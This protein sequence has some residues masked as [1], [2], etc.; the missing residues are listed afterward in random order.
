MVGFVYL[1]VSD[2]S[3][4]LPERWIFD[5][6]PATSVQSRL[7]LSSPSV[8]QTFAALSLSVAAPLCLLDVEER[9]DIVLTAQDRQISTQVPG[10]CL[11]WDKLAPKD[12]AYRELLARLTGQPPPTTPRWV[13]GPGHADYEAFLDSLTR[14]SQVTGAIR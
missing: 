6:T 11:L 8:R 7:F 2:G 12:E 1:M 3:S 10:P 5:F 13:V 4:L 9:F 14:N